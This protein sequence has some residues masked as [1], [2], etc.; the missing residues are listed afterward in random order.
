MLFRSWKK[1][2]EE[3]RKGIDLIENSAEEER[4]TMEQTS[5][6]IGRAHV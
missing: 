3:E 6:E 1:K 5:I 4:G 2:E